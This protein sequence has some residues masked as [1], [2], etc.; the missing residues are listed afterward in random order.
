MDTEIIILTILII[1]S[2]TFSGIETAIFSLNDIKV[3][4]LVKHGKKGAKTLKKLKENPHK[5]L[6]TI[7]VGNNLVNVGAS[8]LATVIVT[9]ALGPSSV[10]L[11]LGIATG[12]MTFI[13]LVFGEITPKAFA[14]QNAEKISL[15]SA[16]P[17]SILM[18]FQSPG[19]WLLE[20]ITGFIIKMMGSEPQKGIITIDELWTTISVGAEEGII[21]KDEEEM[22]HK[23]F[24]FGSTSVRE[25]MIPRTDMFCLK[26]DTKIKDVLKIIPE[27]RY[28]RIPV[29]MER[30]DNIIGILYVKDIIK[31][32]GKKD[33]VYIE[34]ILRPPFF[35]PETKNLNLLLKE[36]RKKRTHLA[37]VVDESGGVAGLVTLEDVLEE[38]VGE[39]YDETD[40]RE[41][42]IK[43]TKDKSFEVEGKTEIDEINRI[44]KFDLHEEHFNTIAGYVIHKLGR[45]PKK[46]EKFRLDK[47]DIIVLDA[48]DQKINKLEIKL[49]G[50]KTS[51]G[52][53]N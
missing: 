20:K 26:A 18:R 6:I 33:D 7:L 30:R 44:L 10:G 3:R 15:L 17:I 13:L 14:H 36:F 45:I 12:L 39:I 43:P 5:L 32:I 40:A 9:N 24:D 51:N 35:V 4:N 42:L 2:G 46:G 47:I 8:T 48:D 49:T 53:T 31:F 34:K 25:I 41:T 11:S 50:T 27:N 1:L 37:L 38:I 16:K 21:K 29:Y 28:T 19:I 22:I 23:V 52:G